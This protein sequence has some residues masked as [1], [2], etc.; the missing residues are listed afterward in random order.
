MNFKTIRAIIVAFSFDLLVLSSPVNN[1]EHLTGN[2]DVFV[3][4]VENSQNI[5]IKDE[6]EIANVTNIIYEKEEE[7]ND[8][9]D[10]EVDSF[11]EETDSVDEEIDSSI[12]ETD[13]VD[14]EDDNVCNTEECI[15]TAK[16]FLTSM[17]TSI[18]PCEDFYKFTCGNFNKINN[19]NKEDKDIMNSTNDYYQK[20]NDYK[21]KMIN[22]LES[23]FQPNENLSKQ[24]QKYDEIVNNKLKNFYKSCMDVDTINKKGTK[25]LVDLLNKLQINERKE[26]YIN[27]S[28]ELAK[29][30]AKFYRITDVRNPLFN[31]FYFNEENRN[32]NILLMNAYPMTTGMDKEI[33]K[34]MLSSVFGSSEGKNIDKMTNNVI[35]F[36]NKLFNINNSSNNS[37]YEDITDLNI[38][39]IKT[40]NEEVPNINWKLYFK[41]VLMIA[42]VDDVNI[43]DL[44]NDE[45]QITYY[46]GKYFK[47]LKNI[48]DEVDAETLSDYLECF[49]INSFIEYFSNN[50][51][52]SFLGTDSRSDVCYTYVNNIM[53]LFEAKYYIENEFSPSIKV[54]T[55]IMLE[56]IKQS[57]LNRIAKMEWLDEETKENAI[58]KVDGIKETIGYKDYIMDSKFIYQEYEPLEIS[59]DDFFN[60]LIS[61]FSYKKKASLR[62]I[63]SFNAEKSYE[64]QPQDIMARYIANLNKIFIPAGILN[65]KYRLGAPDYINYG[66]IGS[67]IGHEL[68]HAFDNDGKNYGPNGEY[69]NWW[70]ENDSKEYENLTKCFINEYNQL[71]FEDRSGDKHY[72]NGELTLNENLA[73]IGGLARAYESWK[74]SLLEDPE[75]AKQK[76]K[77]LPG[78]TQYTNDQ[79]FFIS[80]GKT[81]CEDMNIY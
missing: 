65:A 25:P 80:F 79:L 22:Y 10:E 8:F 5:P 28:D 20:E 62:D 78:L 77:Q 59:E 72:I 11:I 9:L 45:T 40:L 70:T 76:N 67:I 58:K 17:D 7:V 49:I 71:Y 34:D 29:I 16:D 47:H 55:E 21:K 66:N 52:Q 54:N 57:M 26:V 3:S 41:E 43:D 15:Q 14:K 6:I 50:T 1:E 61:S 73:D 39:S 63:I 81:W 13:S 35:E 19:Q 36:E 69:T 32:I 53:D 60:N 12:E 37:E 44:I 31:S 46:N 23:D 38:I 42:D 68:T 75:T 74:L 4:D 64:M 27:S 18:D 56:Y 24:D 30:L 2:V 51:S 48:L 33:L